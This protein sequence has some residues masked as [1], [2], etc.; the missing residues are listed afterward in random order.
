MWHSFQD[1]SQV[2]TYIT[3]LPA[4]GFE[5][6]AVVAPALYDS[7]ASSINYTTFRVYAHSNHPL[8]YFGAVPDSGYSVDNLA[9]HV[10]ENLEAAL[11]V[12]HVNLYWK[13]VPDL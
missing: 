5:E 6:Y 7:V 12:N 8:M 1:G 9:P 3:Q 4:M 13:G 11:V 2:W 10:P